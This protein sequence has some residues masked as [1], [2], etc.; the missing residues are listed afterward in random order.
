[1]GDYLKSRRVQEKLGFV[2]HH[3]FAGSIVPAVKKMLEKEKEHWDKF[4][5]DLD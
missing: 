4:E 1:V 3:T 2:Y 5:W